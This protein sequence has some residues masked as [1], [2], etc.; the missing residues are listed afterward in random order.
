MGEIEKLEELVAD[1]EV[2]SN[3]QVEKFILNEIGNIV[4][5]KM[6][7]LCQY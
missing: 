4:N 2:I 7:E 5:Q 6:E 3:K 1:L